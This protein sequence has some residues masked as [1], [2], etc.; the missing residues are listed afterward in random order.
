VLGEDALDY[1]V[2]F[3]DLGVVGV[4]AAKR[5]LKADHRADGAFARL[6]AKHFEDLFVSR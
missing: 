2:D 3:V 1:L 5:P 6:D 4:L